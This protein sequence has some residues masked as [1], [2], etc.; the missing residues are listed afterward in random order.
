M[1]NL[2]NI[3]ENKNVLDFRLSA[4]WTHNVTMN[5]GFQRE[6]IKVFKGI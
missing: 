3:A 1:Y 6:E 4:M 2:H 5:K